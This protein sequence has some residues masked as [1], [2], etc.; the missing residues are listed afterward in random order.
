YGIAVDS[1]GDA[2]VAGQAG[3]GNFPQKNAF[4]PR[5]GGAADAFVTKLNSAGNALVY[6]TYV[7]GAGADRAYAI[8]VD[9]SG[10]AYLAGS[11]NSTNFPTKNPFQAALAGYSDVFVTKLSTTGKALVYSTYLGGSS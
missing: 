10:S 8:A 4:Q 2:Y 1:L 9:S 11:T 6:S 5:L 3:S 7:G